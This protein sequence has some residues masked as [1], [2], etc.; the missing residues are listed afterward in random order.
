MQAVIGT[1]GAIDGRVRV[2]RKHHEEVLVPRAGLGRRNVA[3]ARVARRIVSLSALV[4][5]AIRFTRRLDP[6]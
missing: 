1:A 6:D 3:V 2:L 4:S 5:R